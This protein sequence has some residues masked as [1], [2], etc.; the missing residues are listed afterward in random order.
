M[1][2]DNIINMLFLCVGAF[3]VFVLMK[4]PGQ[5]KTQHEWCERWAMR[6]TDKPFKEAYDICQKHMSGQRQ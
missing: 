1:K 6:T 3:V 5:M 4:G 2:S